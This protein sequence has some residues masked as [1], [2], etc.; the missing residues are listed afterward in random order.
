MKDTSLVYIWKGF[1]FQD[2]ETLTSENENVQLIYMEMK[3][4]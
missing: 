3:Q 2:F 1:I 4:I